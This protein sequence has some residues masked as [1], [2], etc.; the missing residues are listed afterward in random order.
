MAAALAARSLAHHRE[1][2][3]KVCCGILHILPITLVARRERVEVR[4]RTNPNFSFSLNDRGQDSGRAILPYSQGHKEHVELKPRARPCLFS[5]LPKLTTTHPWNN[6]RAQTP[7]SRHTRNTT[8]QHR[9]STRERQSDKKERNKLA[10]PRSLNYNAQLSSGAQNTS[11]P[12]ERATYQIYFQ[13]SVCSY[14]EP[15]LRS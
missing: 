7:S 10:Q 6:P 8:E 2:D 5:P 4:P 9:Q 14:K 13:Y 12:F 3:V 1:T 11:S 15:M